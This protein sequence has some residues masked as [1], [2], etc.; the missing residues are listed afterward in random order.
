MADA[1]ITLTIIVKVE[2]VE[3][4]LDLMNHLVNVDLQ[5]YNT[6]ITEERV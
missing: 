1:R 6:S 2:Q 5:D 4:A 3:M